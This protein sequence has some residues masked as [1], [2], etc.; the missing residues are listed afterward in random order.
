LNGFRIF[1]PNEKNL[2]TYYP[3][4]WVG[5]PRSRVKKA[6][7]PKSGSATLVSDDTTAY[8]L[9]QVEEKRQ[10]NDK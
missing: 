2:S 8:Q 1:C 9:R 10:K 6:P 3:K 7:D 4:I 5:D